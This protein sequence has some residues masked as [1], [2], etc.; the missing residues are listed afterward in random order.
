V[1]EDDLRGRAA[2]A[3]DFDT[4]RAVS[5]GLLTLPGA[6]FTVF[7]AAPARDAALASAS[8]EM[9]WRNG[10]S[11]GGSAEGEFSSVTLGYAGKAVAR[12]Q[13]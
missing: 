11:L 9:K 13:W 2:W 1:V 7:G 6:F 8:A 10:F 4:N 5:A 12:Y 3:H